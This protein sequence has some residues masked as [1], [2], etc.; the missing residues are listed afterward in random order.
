MT[1]FGINIGRSKQHTVIV[2]EGDIVVY[3]AWRAGREIKLTAKVQYTS[4]DSV[5]VLADSDD[6]WA[7]RHDVIGYDS[8][9]MLTKAG[10]VVWEQQTVAA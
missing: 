2:N 4:T 8:I 5:S 7:R 3:R 10:R 9:V 6:S 1:I